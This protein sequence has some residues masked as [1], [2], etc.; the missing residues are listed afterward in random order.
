MS[1]NLVVDN[2]QTIRLNSESL[3][4][5]QKSSPLSGISCLRDRLKFDRPMT[6][7]YR[8]STTNDNQRRQPIKVT[9]TIYRDSLQT[10][11]DDDVLVRHRES[12]RNNV[13]CQVYNR[14]QV[15]GISCN[16][17]ICWS[18]IQRKGEWGVGA[19][20]PVCSRGKA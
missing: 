13:S 3:I 4:S 12:V 17:S 11:C 8:V 16:Q 7:R 18:F 5:P 15:N 10:A 2:L 20:K 14:Q 1:I 19:K 6:R 9:D